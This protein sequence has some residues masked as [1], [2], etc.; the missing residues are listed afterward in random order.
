MPG[1]RLLSSSTTIDP[2]RE[3]MSGHGSIV[4]MP[5]Q[6]LSPETIRTNRQMNPLCW[7]HFT[8]SLVGKE[9]KWT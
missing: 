4:H 2:A 9:I 5:K 6:A 8:G 7:H 1:A 3:L